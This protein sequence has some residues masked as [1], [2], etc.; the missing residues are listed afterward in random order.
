M[1]NYLTVSAFAL[2]ICGVFSFAQAETIVSQTVDS[3]QTTVIMQESYQALGSG[4]SGVV[5]DVSFE[6]NFP[7]TVTHTYRMDLQLVE[8][9]TNSLN[10]SAGPVCTASGSTIATS[11]VNLNGVSAGTNQFF[12]NWN[13]GNGATLNS[14]K[15]YFLTF[16]PSPYNDTQAGY[17]KGSASN[18]YAAGSLSAFSGESSISP[19]LDAFF[20]LNGVTTGSDTSYTTLN[21]P[22]QASTTAST[23]V[24]FNFSYHAASAQNIS[25]YG[26]TVYNVSQGNQFTV[27]GVAGTGDAT[28]SRTLNLIS[29]NTYRWTAYVCNADGTCYGGA[30]NQFSVV[31][32]VF[33]VGTLNI[34]TST[35]LVYPIGTSSGLIVA[36]V[37]SGVN[38]P[39]DTG[40][41][42]TNASSSINSYAQSFLNFPAFMGRVFP[43][44][45]M[46][47]L[48]AMIQ[49]SSSASSSFPTWEVDF[50]NAS[51]TYGGELLDDVG[52]IPI[53]STSIVETFVSYDTWQTL[54]VIV[55]YMMWAAFAYWFIPRV[56]AVFI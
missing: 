34:G 26:I 52:S 6:I 39:A 42:E 12:A 20:I 19:L 32:S 27:T 35:G 48:G 14:S 44:S 11:S 31:T 46:Y 13:N 29:S 40:I 17:L 28:I 33:N 37:G 10:T 51:T 38:L 49:Q 4:L 3:S 55:S 41:T 2:L 45:W 47:E 22:T 24:N 21:W 18:S 56:W 16:Q 54:R 5:T 8:C 36:P 15:Y 23:Q 7:V 50:S 1:R 25:S 9:S 53:L 43:F 30:Q